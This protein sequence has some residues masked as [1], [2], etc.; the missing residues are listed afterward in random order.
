MHLAPPKLGPPDRA[1][2]GTSSSSSDALALLREGARAT[3]VG[4]Q[5]LT[6]SWVNGETSN[7]AY[8]MA[9][10]AAAGRKM[11][12]GTFH[13]VIPWVTDFSQPWSPEDELLPW[14]HGSEEGGGG[15]G[16]GDY[17]RDEG[18]GGGGGALDD[19]EGFE[20]CSHFRDLRKSKYRINKGDSQLGITFSVGSQTGNRPHHIT[21]SLS[22]ITFYM[23]LARRTPLATLCSVVRPVF[24]AREYPSSMKR[25]ARRLRHCVAYIGTFPGDSHALF[26][27]AK[28]LVEPLHSRGLLIK[29]LWLLCLQPN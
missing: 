16:G 19:E 4:I 11:G 18:G 26:W 6:T 9:L 8:L 24:D 14:Q 22:E 27:K 23:Y 7:L 28:T 17:Y 5:C 25:K 15:G 1:P 3:R 13:P 21:E 20:S 2:R 10:N 29:L 12:D